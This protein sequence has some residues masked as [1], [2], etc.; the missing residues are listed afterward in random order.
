MKNALWYSSDI[1][2][3][4]EIVMLSIQVGIEF[5]SPWIEKKLEGIQVTKK[6]GITANWIT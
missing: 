3:R 2:Y 1:G 6:R 4:Q 5:N